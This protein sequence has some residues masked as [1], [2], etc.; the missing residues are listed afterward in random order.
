MPNHVANHIKFIG[1]PERIKEVLEAIK[2]DEVGIGSI[3]FNKIIPMPDG[4]EIEAGSKTDRG[5]KAYKDFVAVLTFDGANKDIDLLNIP[6][7]KENI[8][9]EQRKDID[10]E[11][12]KLGRQAYKNILQHGAPTWYEWSISN[13][14][15]KWN[16]YSCSKFEETS[17]ECNKIF[18]NTAWSAPHP[19]L[20]KL[21]SMYPD[22]EIEHE[23]ADEDFGQNLGRR[24]FK[25]GENIELY[26]PETDKE[27]YEFAL[28]VQGFESMEVAGRTLN[29]SETN[30][31]PIWF[32]DYD[33]VEFREKKM[34]YSTTRKTLEDI[35]KGYNCYDIKLDSTNTY[36]DTLEKGEAIRHGGTLITKEEIDFGDGT[37]ID[38][39]QEPVLFVGMNQVSFEQFENGEI[40]L[41]EGMEM[42]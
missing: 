33:V 16:A 29:A 13:W 14:G 3:D 21:A 38:L 17:E 10:K 4:L 12:W 42:A 24:T 41:K 7:E 27:A 26:I 6:E 20:N 23:W 18:L 31:I 25:N 34:L 9:L 1:E 2:N 22:L 19:I 5:L 37:C 36:F 40:E 32:E 39:E 15:T 11:D 8:F 30:Y 28:K 35:P